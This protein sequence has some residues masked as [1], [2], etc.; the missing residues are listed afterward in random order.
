[1]ST[2]RLYTLLLLIFLFSCKKENNRIDHI[3]DD[4]RNHFSYQPGTYWVMYDSLRGETDSLYITSNS[5]VVY[6]S[7]ISGPQIIMSMLDSNSLGVSK[8]RL[9]LSAQYPLMVNMPGSTYL[10]TLF[11]KW[12][13]DPNNATWTDMGNVYQN[14]YAQHIHYPAAEDL[15]FVI[16]PDTGFIVIKVSSPGTQQSL[17]LLR[18]KTVH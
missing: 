10:S 11:S 1:M 2:I 15:T 16:H 9:I 13:T 3:N 7:V 12:P 18:H 14:V 5:G 4:L 17:H 6:D 8:W